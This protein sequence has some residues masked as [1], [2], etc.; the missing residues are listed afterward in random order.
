[1]SLKNLEASE[2]T[3]QEMLGVRQDKINRLVSFIHA[4]SFQKVDFVLIRQIIEA[5]EKK[6]LEEEEEEANRR[7]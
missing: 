2:A 7:R 4:Q 5:A 6:R 1:M 3:K